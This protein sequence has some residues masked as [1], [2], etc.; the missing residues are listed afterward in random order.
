ME[1]LSGT[2]QATRDE[3]ASLNAY[4]PAD[5][6]TL[7]TEFTNLTTELNALSQSVSPIAS[8]RTRF[9]ST[10]KAFQ[11]LYNPI[12]SAYE[13]MDEALL[14]L[15]K[16]VNDLIPDVIDEEEEE[17]GEQ[18][19]TPTPNE[20]NNQTNPS[21]TLLVIGGVSLVIIGLIGGTIGLKKRS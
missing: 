18:P 3:L 4:I 11:D 7:E 15:N 1:Q 17:P 10:N 14:E 5:L 9:N 21:Q 16:K 12:E 2:H 19:V 20:G 13:G 8:K 6:E